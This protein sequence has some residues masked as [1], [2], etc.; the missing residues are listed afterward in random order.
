M[1]YAVNQLAR[2]IKNWAGKEISAMAIEVPSVPSATSH[3]A[4]LEP[5][6]ENAAQMTKFVLKDLATGTA[7][8]VD[9]PLASC[10]CGEIVPIPHGSVQNYA[11][12]LLSQKMDENTLVIFMVKH[13]LPPS[14][15]KYEVAKNLK[16]F[17]DKTHGGNS[18]DAV[19]S[20]TSQ[21]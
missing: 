19:K 4:V 1:C 6:P 17:L 10:Y 2:K 21:K 7:K 12:Y 14:L 3:A 11:K 9:G 20:R 5:A 13:N 18:S 8:T 15:N 16:D